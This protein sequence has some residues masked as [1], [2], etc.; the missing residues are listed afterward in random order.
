MA[1]S[2]ASH[3]LAQLNL[4]ALALLR[5]TLAAPTEIERV[6]RTSDSA[7]IALDQGQA[8]ETIVVALK[9]SDNFGGRLTRTAE[10]PRP[11]YSNVVTGK[12]LLHA[13]AS[14]FQS[15]AELVEMPLRHAV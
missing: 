10:Y 3:E 11:R 2:N 1:L 6:V 15:R 7:R 8:A 5:P 13:P 12:L 4:P 14:A 9:I